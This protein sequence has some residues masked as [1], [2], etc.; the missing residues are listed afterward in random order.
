MRRRDLIFGGLGLAALATSE[1]LRPRRRLKLLQ[2]GTI[3]SSLPWA[4]G[5]WSAEKSSDYI[6]P[7][8]AGAVT[9]ALYSELVPRTYF[10][11]ETGDGV[12]MLAAYGDTQSDLLQLHRPE[13]C[14][15]AVGF[16]LRLSQPTQ[17][18]LVGKTSLPG[19]RVVAFTEERTENII[20]W[21]RMGEALPQSAGE[22]RNTRIAQSIEGIIPDGILMRL[23]VLGESQHGFSVL[24]RFIPPMLRAI[25][26]AQRKAFIGTNLS[27][28]LG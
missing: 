19:R 16:N 18:P 11:S 3:E 15:P 17:V 26:M 23:S 21:T 9:R 22:Q 12:M 4:F 1:A 2:G 14:Y 27:K 13:F 28:A 24:E 20:Y 6:G 7:E 5:A 8:L 10:N 25:P